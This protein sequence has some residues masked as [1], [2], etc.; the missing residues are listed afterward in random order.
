MPVYLTVIELKFLHRLLVD[1]QV[2]PVLTRSQVRLVDSSCAELL[3]DRLRNAFEALDPV[4]TL[5]SA[6]MNTIQ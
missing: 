6:C 1:N 4:N 3:L 5:N 2:R